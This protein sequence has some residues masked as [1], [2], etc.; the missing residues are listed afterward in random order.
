MLSRPKSETDTSTRA[1]R[2]RTGPT[3]SDSSPADAKSTTRSEQ[4][5]Y[6]DG[7]LPSTPPSDLLTLAE[8]ARKLP[9]QRSAQSL[10]NWCR[11]GIK[12]RNGER[13]YLRHVRI[14]KRLFT[15]SE[16]MED[17]FEQLAE[18][19]LA[20]EI[21]HPNRQ[22]TRHNLVDHERADLELREAGL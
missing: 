1:G 19:D 4:S 11:K 13:Y 12:A 14:G 9:R 15:R 8:A 21:A 6:D 16:W 5:N 2:R 10:W 3:G 20:R 7:P 22:K 18:A 17:F